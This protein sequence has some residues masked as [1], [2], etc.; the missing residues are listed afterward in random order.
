MILLQQLAGLSANNGQLEAGSTTTAST[1]LPSSPPWALRSATC[2]SIPFFRTVSL[3]AIVPESECRIPILMVSSACAAENPN[4][5]ELEHTVVATSARSQKRRSVFMG[6]PLG[7]LST[8]KWFYRS[9]VFRAG[10]L[11]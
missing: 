1:F 7:L 4:R 8:K 5:L 10:A 3:M 2:I 6:S 9:I 11:M